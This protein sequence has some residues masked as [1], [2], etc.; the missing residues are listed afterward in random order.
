MLHQTLMVNRFN[1]P[2]DTREIAELFAEHDRTPLPIE[3][4]VSRR[5]LF[6]YRDLYMH[7]IETHGELMPNL[8]AAREDPLFQK[9]NTRLGTLLS[10]Y[11]SNWSEMEDSRAEVFYDWMPDRR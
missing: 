2:S 1:D 5:T 9:V 7:L 10:R 4:G 11:D 3:L 8:N 6:R